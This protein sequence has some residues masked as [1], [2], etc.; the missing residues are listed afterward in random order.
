MT[1]PIVILYDVSDDC[2]VSDYVANVALF[3]ESA[4]LSNKKSS[5]FTTKGI[6]GKIAVIINTVF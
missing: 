3:F 1:I 2:L 6:N 5:R 4:K